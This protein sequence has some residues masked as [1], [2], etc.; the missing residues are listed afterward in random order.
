M[1][2]IRKNW[3]FVRR[4]KSWKLSL[5]EKEVFVKMMESLFEDGNL[6]NP[7]F[8]SLPNKSVCASLWQVWISSSVAFRERTR[9]QRCNN[10]VSD[11]RAQTLCNLPPCSGWPLTVS[12]QTQAC[13]IISWSKARPVVG[14]CG[15]PRAKTSAPPPWD[16]VHR[17]FSN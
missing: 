7:F 8:Q 14:R 4:K 15:E 11:N 1:I 13:F 3:I 5:L 6:E 12:P 9:S 2:V 10:P 16:P 17:S